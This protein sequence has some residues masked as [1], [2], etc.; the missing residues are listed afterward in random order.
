MTGQRLGLLAL[1]TSGPLGTIV[2][3]LLPKGSGQGA[4]TQAPS[5]VRALRL[6]A[7]GE[8]PFRPAGAQL[9]AASFWRGSPLAAEDAELAAR[10]LA[11]SSPD[12]ALASTLDGFERRLGT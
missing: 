8:Q 9:P 11:S 2:L 4:V 5:P 3:A 12:A 1:T 10:L 7:I 6:S